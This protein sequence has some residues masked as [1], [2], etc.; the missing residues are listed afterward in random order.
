MTLLS[1]HDCRCAGRNAGR[2]WIVGLLSVL[3]WSLASD[4]LAAQTAVPVPPSSQASAHTAKQPGHAKSARRKSSRKKA[5]TAA[6]A[7]AVPAAPP[8]PNWPVN[9]KAQPAQVSWN[10]HGLQVDAANSS[11][12]QI[13]ADVSAATGTKVV[14]LSRDE[15]IFGTY[16]PGPA[17]DVLSQLLQGA[18]YNILM[19][20]G[21][22]DAAP[23]QLLLTPRTAGANASSSA[24]SPIASTAAEEEPSEPAPEEPPQPAPP[25]SAI[26]PGFGQPNAPP[27]TPQQILQQMQQRQAQSPPEQGGPPQNQ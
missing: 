18:G 26:N 19:T 21:A 12:I 7:P 11:L 23:Q 2:L 17:R 16:G 10:S 14:G 27:R 22:G 1:F 9:D 3:C 20:G 24:P 6:A 13:L 5:E 15:R 4:C 8:M 25:P